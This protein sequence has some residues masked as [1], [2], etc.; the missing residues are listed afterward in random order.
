MKPG[1]GHVGNNFTYR[2]NRLRNGSRQDSFADHTHDRK[3]GIIEKKGEFVRTDSMPGQEFA[4]QIRP[5]R[6]TLQRLVELTN[7]I[8]RA[9]LIIPSVSLLTGAALI[10]GLVDVERRPQNT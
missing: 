1:V 9:H 2:H 6:K 4:L 7:K 5:P 3:K 8:L 10:D